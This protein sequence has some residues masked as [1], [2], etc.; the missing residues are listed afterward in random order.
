MNLLLQLLVAG[1]I[2]TAVYAFVAVGFSVIFSVSRLFHFAHASIYPLAAYVC[3]SV[4]QTAGLGTGIA[5]GI[6]AAVLA[7]LAVEFIVYRRMRRR[8]AN[9]A[10]LMMASLGIQIL[11]QGVMG[12]VWGTEPLYIRDP[13]P[14]APIVLG[15]IAFTRLELAM[16]LLA[17]AAVAAVL[18]F[19]TA[20]KP[21]R[22]LLAVAEEPTMAQIVGISETRMRLL[23]FALGTAV[24]TPAAILVGMRSGLTPDMGAVPLLFAFAA[25]VVGG[26]G[27]IRG[28]V[29]GLLLLMAAASLAVYRLPTYWAQGIAFAILLAFM[30]WRPRGLLG[31]LSRAGAA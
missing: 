5:A 28:T 26:I 24:S 8:Q 10:T 23:A 21:G 22:A 17:A 25:V 2:T 14:R 31:R 18:V 11:L 20:T 3:F 13:L 4:A 19:A 30:L 12:S 29:L 27:S 9:P 16:V 15:P 1:L 6:A 7:A